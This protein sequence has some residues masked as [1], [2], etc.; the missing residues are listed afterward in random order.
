MDMKRVFRVACGSL[1][2]VSIAV[3][4][5][6][7][8]DISVDAV[9]AASLNNQLKFVSPIAVTATTATVVWT[10]SHTDG[11]GVLTY[12]STSADSKTITLS[13]AQR[14][15]KS[16]DLTGLTPNTTYNIDLL[17][18]KPGETSAEATGKFTTKA[19]TSAIKPLF[20]NN[21][22]QTHLEHSRLILG[23]SVLSGDRVIV[24]E[25]TGRKVMNHTVR[26]NEPSID[27]PAAG[28]H[29]YVVS[30]QRGGASTYI[31]TLL[32]GL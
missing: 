6:G 4:F 23:S 22:I 5:A 31:G 28:S 17:L 29:A 13:A 16:I 32:S 11:S 21:V 2:A 14:A 24:F 26:P 3:S 8:R 9:T 7:T 10:F 20:A 18:S 12:A 15:A 19:G 30:I 1:Y 25:A 27:M